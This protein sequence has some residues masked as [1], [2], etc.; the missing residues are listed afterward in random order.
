M[1]N[2]IDTPVYSQIAIDIAVRIAKG[3]L[4]EGTRISGRSL[5]AGEYNVSPET[6]RRS[7]RLLEDM[8]IV[9]VL[10]GS[11]VTIK[12]R[13]D[14]LQYIEKYN[15]GKDLRDLKAD[16]Y[17]KIE[18]RNALNQEILENVEHMFDLSERLRNINPIHIMEFEVPLN[19]PLLGKMIADVQFWQST[20][21]T[22][23]GIKREGKVI[24][25]PGPYACF[26]PTDIILFIGDTGV[27]KRVERIMREG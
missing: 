25:S 11:G 7:L 14:A 15:T 17:K 12:S 20:G 13:V 19:S 27:F 1:K 18:E 22:I 6:I 9:E 21:A 5:L 2:L 8:G 10:T 24:V 23:V 26:M 3:E 16:I 4:K